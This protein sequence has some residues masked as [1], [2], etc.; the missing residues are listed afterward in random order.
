MMLGSVFVGLGLYIY[1][2]MKDHTDLFGYT[3]NT[4]SWILISIGLIGTACPVI[5]YFLYCCTWK[6]E[7]WCI[8][9]IQSSEYDLIV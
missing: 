2:V 3:Y 4:T 6:F 1:I 8:K 7:K 5:V 9:L